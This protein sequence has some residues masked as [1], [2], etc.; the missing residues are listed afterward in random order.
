MLCA[1]G[2]YM[3]Y[4]LASF[5]VQIHTALQLVGHF[6]AELRTRNVNY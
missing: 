5:P 6:Q 4:E 2:I 3:I 1:V